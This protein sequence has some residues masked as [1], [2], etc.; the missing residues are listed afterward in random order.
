MIDRKQRL[1][2]LKNLIRRVEN[3]VNSLQKRTNAFSWYRLFIFLAGIISSFIFF[4]ID[5]NITIGSIFFFVIVFNIVAY[6]HRR[7]EISLKKHQI[8]LHIKSTHLARMQL[9]WEKIPNPPYYKPQTDHPFEIDLDIKGEKSLHHLLDLSISHN[10]SERLLNWLLQE[11]PDIELI[12]KRQRLIRELMPQTRFRDRL[13]LSFQ[14][15]NPDRLQGKKLLEWFKHTRSVKVFQRILTASSILAL[16]NWLLFILSTLN[17]LSNKWLILSLTVYIIIYFYFSHYHKSIFEDATFLENEFQQSMSIFTFLEH[18]AYA[19]TPEL[20]HLCTPFR[21]L[22]VKPTHQLHTIKLITF[23]IGLR[24]NYLFGLILNIL[25]PWDFY[26]GYQLNRLKLKLQNQFPE[27]LDI[28]FELEALISLANFGYLNPEYHFPA[29]QKAPSISKMF[30]QAKEL[31]HPLIAAE[32]RICNDIDLNVAKQ[33]VLI[34]G[35]NMS[36]KSTFLRTVGI[37]LCLAFAGAPVNAQICQTSIF[38]LFTCVKVNDSITGGFSQFY[39]EVKRLKILLERLNSAGE[40]PIFFLIDEIFKGTNNRERLIGSR[41]YTQNL[42]GKNGFGII[43][44]HDLELT[45][46]AEI[47]KNIHNNHFKEDVVKGQMIFDYKLRP[48]PCP[49]TNAL[50]IMHLEGLPVPEQEMKQI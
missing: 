18:Y 29:V 35:S 15:V 47:F 38:N 43:T 2:A 44:T 30:F 10:G 9:I 1:K 28:C 17:F 21:N 26:W 20:A 46:L 32:N 37:N 33:I 16:F 34:T 4:W 49:T 19:Q 50:I 24:M 39:A 31:G 22:R 41:A 48:G 7:C 45:R 23:A 25:F 36:G 3:Q 11:K 5:K 42:I 27:W 40:T 13:L 12:Q 14:L 6:Y 8:W